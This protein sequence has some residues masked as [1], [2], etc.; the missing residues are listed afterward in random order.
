MKKVY[1]NV[2]PELNSNTY[3]DFIDIAPFDLGNTRS[4]I[5]EYPPYLEKALKDMNKVEDE[6]LV[7]K[8]NFSRYF[9]DRPPSLYEDL[10]FLG[11]TG[12]YLINIILQV[13]GFML[14]CSSILILFKYLSQIQAY[15]GSGMT[16]VVVG[17]L[18]FY[19]LLYAFLLS[20][21]LRWYTI[22][23]SVLMK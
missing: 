11:S 3:M 12:F 15:Y 23:T 13:T 18:V 4:K 2:V 10:V 22:I 1:R 16:Y 17:V 6:I 8:L 7:S 20:L 5:I 9:Y 21:N 14:I 19:V